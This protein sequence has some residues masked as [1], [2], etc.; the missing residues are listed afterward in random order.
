MSFATPAD[1]LDRRR[2][3]ILD[4]DADGFAALFAPDAVIEMPFEGTPEAPL[5]LAG[6]EAIGEYARRMVASL[7]RID[8]FDVTAVHQT[9][10]PEVIV[11]E[12]NTKGSITT[13]GKP[14][15]VMSVQILRI[16]D[17][18]I[19]LFRAYGDPR[20]AAQLRS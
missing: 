7:L 2:Q 20:L 8:G 10:D 12:V 9:Q 5:C 13:T 18:R 4:G 15:S 6:R 1:L 17:G 16:R 3:V 19:A 14:F 11:V